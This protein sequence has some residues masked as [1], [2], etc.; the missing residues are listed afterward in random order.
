M[1]RD[2]SGHQR[3]LWALE[4]LDH[5]ATLPRLLHRRV[6]SPYPPH[7]SLFRVLA[8]IVSTRSSSPRRQA[9]VSSDRTSSPVT[10]HCESPVISS[11]IRLRK[12][13]NTFL[14]LRWLPSPTVTALRNPILLSTVPN[15]QPP[16]PIRRRSRRD[17]IRKWRDKRP[18]P[19]RL[20]PSRP[21]L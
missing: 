12:I 6:S 19:K 16:Y 13:A 18:S 20:H 17:G 3:V 15:C 10:P 14:A 7:I 1:P 4:I 8:A 21:R 2:G 5:L 9:S 11:E